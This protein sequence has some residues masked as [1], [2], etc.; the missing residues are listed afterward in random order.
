MITQ[1]T[2]LPNFFSLGLGLKLLW[3]DSDVDQMLSTAYTTCLKHLLV[4][5]VVQ[6]LQSLQ[7]NF[8]Y[9]ILWW[10][11]TVQPVISKKLKFQPAYI[12]RIEVKISKKSHGHESSKYIHQT[13]V[14][15][16]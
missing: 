14:W 15:G 10:Q 3:F 5:Y 9:F 2:F 12:L 6:I 1:G 13:L 4:I 11:Q 7:K 16:A 8:M